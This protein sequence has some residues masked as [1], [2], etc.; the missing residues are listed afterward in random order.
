LAAKPALPIAV[1]TTMTEPV[2]EVWVAPLDKVGFTGERAACTS[3]R[4]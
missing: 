2:A 1:G 4:P 3:I